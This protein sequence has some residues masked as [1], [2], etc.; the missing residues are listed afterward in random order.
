MATV[1][2]GCAPTPDMGAPATGPARVWLPTGRVGVPYRAAVGVDLTAVTPHLPA[3]L[4]LG[5]GAGGGATIVGAP[6][7]SGHH[8]L[9]GRTDDGPGGAVGLDL[10][11]LPAQES[12]DPDGSALTAPGRFVVAT[13]DVALGAADLGARSAGRAV[14]LY[15]PEEAPPGLP[16]VVFQHGSVPLATGGK[17]PHLRFAPLLERWASHGFAVASV[18]GLDLLLDGSERTPQ[19]SLDHLQRL[20]ANQRAALASLR[21]RAHDA[22]FP[23]RGRIDFDRVVVAGHSRGGGASLLSLQADP[24]L[25]GGILIKPVDPLLYA[26]APRPAPLPARPILLI[27]AEH[28]VDV[29]FPIADY[30]YE[31]RTGP[32]AAVTLLGD[33]HA[34]TCGEGCPPEQE[35]QRL[36]SI[37]PRHDWAVSNAY[38]LAFLEY[39]AR[40]DLRR[41][42]LVFGAPGL[43]S[44][45]SPRGVL[46][47]ADRQAAALLVDDFQDADPDHNH[48]GLA[49]GASGVSR[50]GEVSWLDEVPN[51]L[52]QRFEPRVAA[53]YGD[54]ALAALARGRLL[55]GAS[56]GAV[57][58][59]DLGGLDVGAREVFVGR[60]LR[61]QEPLAAETLEL[62]FADAAGRVHAVSAA[63]HLG[64]GGLGPR[65]AD[66]IV[67]VE[68]LRAAGLDVGALARLQVVLQ[69]EGAVYLDDLRFE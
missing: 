6:L 52:G 21:R 48:L 31:R 66:V 59:T 32:M 24:A 49:S 11:I 1:G 68:T 69:A 2:P 7:D 36:A 53:L 8:R 58:A 64:A 25:L 55:A 9:I 29:S 54:P 51:Q 19:D 67:P 63:R 44:G 50:T 41:A 33:V 22:D 62:R 35:E 43:S 45:L 28:D 23:L 39:V 26:A 14:R 60:F 46:V 40:G 3:G 57:F 61:L 42:P 20:S 37:E 38:A 34:F 65:F 15:Y 30:L 18:D 56:P 13:W 16:L 17:P 12:A 4:A 27:I 10:S 47:R 5:R